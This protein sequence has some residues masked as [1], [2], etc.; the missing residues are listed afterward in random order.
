MFDR[1]FFR[2]KKTYDLAME[3]NKNDSIK[4]DTSDLKL[5]EDAINATQGIQYL[6]QLH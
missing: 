5:I 2:G 3:I 4:I 1:T 6:I